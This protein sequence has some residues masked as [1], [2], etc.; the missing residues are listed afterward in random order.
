MSETRLN[1][2]VT[3]ASDLQ[4]L[5]QEAVRN[6]EAFN[7]WARGTK[8]S[9]DVVNARMTSFGNTSELAFNQFGRAASRAQVR[10]KRF[11]SVGLQQAGYQIGDFAVQLQG[12]TNAMVALG[13]QGSQL[14]GIFGPYGAVAG[15]VLA[16]GTAIAAPLWAARNAAEDAADGADVF[17]EAVENAK[18]KT[19]ELS[20]ELKKL[21][22]GYQ[23]VTQA[24]LYN[25]REQAKVAEQEA[26]TALESASDYSGRSGRGAFLAAQREV[27]SA[28][29]A[30]RLARERILAYDELLEKTNRLKLAE[31]EANAELLLGEQM[32]SRARDEA[33]AQYE[34]HVRIQEEIAQGFRNRY[35][36]ETRV[37]QDAIDS[38][39]TLFNRVQDLK[40]KYG[41]ATYEAIRLSGVDLTSN[42]T[43]AVAE[44]ARLAHFLGMSAD[45]FDA[46]KGMSLV[47]ALGRNMPGGAGGPQ[48]LVNKWNGVPLSEGEIVNEGMFDVPSGG[49]GGAGPDPM[50]L[51]KSIM[52]PSEALQSEYEQRLEQLKQFNDQE[53]ALVGG[54]AEAR[55]RIEEDLHKGLNDI[56]TR[57]RQDALSGLSSM[58]GDLSSLM[59]TQSRGLFA[60]GK[61]A[62]MAETV[63][64]GIASAEKAWNWG[65]TIGGPPLAAAF[66]GAS[67]ASTAA[68]LAAISSQNFGGASSGS[69]SAG[70]GA[71]P[72]GASATI[73]QNQTA[74]QQPQRVLIEGL[75]TDSLISGQQL[76]DLFDRLYEENSERGAIFMVAR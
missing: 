5:T 67:A 26:L 35:N 10:A 25:A 62:A 47:D 54:H 29:E 13:Q 16:V 27:T 45:R 57:E 48:G 49:S 65:M 12:G 3:G 51:M 28:E 2:K 60:I 6:R 66:A 61:A 14:L 34:K 19:S 44:A 73:Q 4:A 30:L 56:R 74:P 50:G 9:F 38:Y 8:S 31:K 68:R 18:K 41:E 32:A 64:S 7:K 24:A 1:V 46:I 76:S 33:L 63:V 70:T 42:I 71:T 75:S 23:D 53:L 11:A 22:G 37:N 43:P 72:S 36:A 20:A 17:A 40:E 55:R 39:V 52:T 59:N 15:A 21:E 58:F 69:I